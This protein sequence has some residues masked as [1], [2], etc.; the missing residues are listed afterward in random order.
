[1]RFRQFLCF[2]FPK[3]S[4]LINDIQYIIHD[5][6]D[7][8][9]S[10]LHKGI[11]WNETL[12]FFL[13]YYIVSHPIQHFINVGCHIGTLCL[14]ISKHVKHVTAFEAY[15]PTYQ[16][17]KQNIDFN[18]ITN[19]TH[20]NMA[21]GDR[22]DTIYFF[23]EHAICPRE[24]INRFKK[25]TGGMHVL[26][27]YDIDHQIRSSSLSDRKIIGSMYRFDEL[28]IP[29]FDLLL[30]DVEGME[31]EFLKGAQSK[32][33]QCKPIILIEIWNNEK[34]RIENM[35]TTTEH[36]IDF[37]LSLG[38]RLVHQINE[39]YIFE[40]CSSSFV[41]PSF[42]DTMVHWIQRMYYHYFSNIF[43]SRSNC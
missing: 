6:T 37:I 25:N 9:Q 18:H 3:I 5:P 12:Y 2:F 36:V 13:M 14:P 11:Q 15:P 19:I 27:Q 43:S 17:F 38:Y 8:I 40:P 22:T 28:D 23:S 33:L 32:I 26:T 30:V 29:P 20:Y 24:K 21:L 7:L 35:E 16:H 41:L 39:D 1:M 42:F 31:Y 10:F 4:P 34:R